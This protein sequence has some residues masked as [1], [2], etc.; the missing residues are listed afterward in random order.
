MAHYGYPL[1]SARF[2]SHWVL[3]KGL[4]LCSRRQICLCD[5]MA[6]DMIAGVTPSGLPDRILMN[7]VNL[8][9]GFS[10]IR[11][12][13]QVSIMPI[14]DGLRSPRSTSLTHLLL[15]LLRLIML[16]KLHLLLIKVQCDEG[17]GIISCWVSS[18]I[19]AI[20]PCSPLIH[21]CRSQI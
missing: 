2:S 17:R 13:T 1:R 18:S 7:K 10:E 12:G 20:A 15:L 16:V 5:I 9:C 8:L 3:T 11:F 4:F 19:V 14:S 6:S 21:V